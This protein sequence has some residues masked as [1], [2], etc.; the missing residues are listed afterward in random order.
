[1]TGQ[2]WANMVFIR[3]YPRLL[4]II[5]AAVKGVFRLLLPAT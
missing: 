4:P 2:S 3:I 1:M 5:G